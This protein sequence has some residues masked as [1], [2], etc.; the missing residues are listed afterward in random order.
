MVSMFASHQ[1]QPRASMCA[2]RLLHLQPFSSA[3]IPSLD[4][5]LANSVPA[6]Q[7]GRD[8]TAAGAPWRRR[9]K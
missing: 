1:S 4:S 2:A 7:C 5:S 9:A 3:L 8:A 6:K